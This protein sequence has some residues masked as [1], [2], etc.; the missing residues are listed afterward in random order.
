[1]AGCSIT[2]KTLWLYISAMRAGMLGAG[3]DLDEAD[4]VILRC[5]LRLDGHLC[6][7]DF[8]LVPHRPFVEALVKDG[9][10]RSASR[11]ATEIVLRVEHENGTFM[12]F[13]DAE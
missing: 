10:F 4:C 9:L 2:A 5:R 13:I 8:H 3:V 12:L 7:S 11:A 6:V 1:M